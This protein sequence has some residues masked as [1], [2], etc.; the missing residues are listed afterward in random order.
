MPEASGY[1]PMNIQEHIHRY[2]EL[3]ARADRL[4]A[5]VERV[6]GDLM[7]CKPGCDDCCSVYFELAL[8][9]AFTLSG[10]FRRHVK[11]LRRD[12]V[13]ARAEKAE[14]LFLEAERLLSGVSASGRDDVVA[15]AS[16]LKIPCPLNEDGCCVMYEFRPIT[17]RIYGTP[18]N[19]GDRVV[20]CP[21]TGFVKGRKYTAVN[22]DAIHRELYEYSREFLIDLI[23]AAPTVPPGP[24]FSIPLAL[25]TSFDKA[26][27]V[28]LSQA[29]E[30]ED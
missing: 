6:H 24:L 10:M 12:R 2:L 30:K 22:V 1:P 27:F 4:F 28:S 17:C 5:S 8:I 16:R 15:C 25:K 11:G 9:E 13:L 14:P 26:F 20:S 19:I 21:R 3:A 18:Q 29:L 23:G 7:P